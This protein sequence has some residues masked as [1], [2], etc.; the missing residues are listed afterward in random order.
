MEFRQAVAGDIPKI[1]AVIDQAKAYFKANGIDQWQQGYPNRETVETDL[2]QGFAYVL[3]EGNTVLAYSAVSFDGEPNYRSIEEGAWLT[4]GPYVVIHRT[5]VEN[6]RKG[7]GLAGIFLG[8]VEELCRKKQ[9]HSM[10]IDTHEQ[11]ASMRRMLEKNGFVC[12]GVIHLAD[13]APRMAY[14]KRI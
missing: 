14:E 6:G 12:C 5:A 4:S 8:H 10:R 11:N 13:G 9:I 7:Q 3:A 1:L 2:E